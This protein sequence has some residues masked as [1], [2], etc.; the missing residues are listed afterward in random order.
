MTKDDIKPLAEI[1]NLLA[2]GLDTEMTTVKHKFYHSALSDLSIED[3]K[4]AA[5][6]IA[7]T[8]TFFPKPVDFRNAISGNMEDNAINSWTK[9]LKAKN[10]YESVRFDDL[11]I[12]STIEAMGGWIKFCTMEEYD[13]EK[14][15]MTD[16]IKI[17][18]AVAS[19]GEHPDYLSGRLEL[20]NT[21][22]NY[23]EFVP[24]VKLIGDA[25]EIKKIVG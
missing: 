21:A 8:A 3:I 19:R 20:E 1:L 23:L 6:H 24:E 22:N 10:Q 17:Y 12:H 2:A 4:K 5:N 15:Q 16:F 11:V 14:W 25:K 7:R 13:S 18:K 9:A